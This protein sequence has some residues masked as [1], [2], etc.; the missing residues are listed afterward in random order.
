MVDFD[1][2]HAITE[3][4]FWEKRGVLGK[5]ENPIGTLRKSNGIWIIN[6]WHFFNES[7]TD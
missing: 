1:S 2:K 7:R 4:S 6:T 5:D 3:G